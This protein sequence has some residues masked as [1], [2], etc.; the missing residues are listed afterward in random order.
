MVLRDAA[1]RILATADPAAKVALSLEAAAAWR[2]GAIGEAGRATPPARPARPE[3]PL[4]LAPK[5]MPKRSTGAL[6]RVALIHALAHIEL[7]ALDLAWDLLARFPDIDWPR[8][9]FDDYVKVAEDEAIHFR[10]LAD[11]LAA[12]GAAY[13]DHP[14]HDGLWEAAGQTAGDPLGRLAVV[15]MVLEARGLDVTPETIRRFAAQGDDETAALLRRIYEDEIDHVAI[16][17]RWFAWLCARDGLPVAETWRAKVREHFRG[18]LKPPFN[19]EA[20]ARAGMAPGLYQPLAS[21]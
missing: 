3:R 13:G 7:N 8:A 14:A 10:L 17:S 9:F 1:C 20:R 21:G 6:G 4:L 18:R 12:F 19:A 11:R 5:H 15:P 2:D 16:G